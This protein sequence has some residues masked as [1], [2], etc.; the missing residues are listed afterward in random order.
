MLSVRPKSGA[1]LRMRGS[2][3]VGR[4]E[5]NGREQSGEGGMGAPGRVGAEQRREAVTHGDGRVRAAPR[6]TAK[7]LI[8]G[9]IVQNVR[10]IEEKKTEPKGGVV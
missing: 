4:P 6:S 10:G 8:R 2:W 5:G 7:V 9:S 1:I 3:R